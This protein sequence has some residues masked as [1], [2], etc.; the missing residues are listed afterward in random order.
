VRHRDPHNDPPHNRQ[1]KLAT[2]GRQAWTTAAQPLQVADLFWVGYP[3]SA[4]VALA[5][6]VI[7]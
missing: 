3:H 4:P 6:F 2:P 5:P 7:R 1:R